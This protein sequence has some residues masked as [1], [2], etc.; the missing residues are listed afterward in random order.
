MYCPGEKNETV[1]KKL[2]EVFKQVMEE[3]HR[4][5]EDYGFQEVCSL[6]T[7]QNIELI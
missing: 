5:E 1:A 6:L 7:S 3:S 4:R 2:V